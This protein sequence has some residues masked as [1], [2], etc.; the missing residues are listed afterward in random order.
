MKTQNISN[1]R[2]L[3]NEVM[4]IKG[5]SPVGYTHQV[6]VDQDL[7]EWEWNPDFNGFQIIYDDGS[8]G[9]RSGGGRQKRPEDGRFH[10]SR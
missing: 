7:D 6:Y 4:D 3:L 2:D 9:K 5:V 10:Q 1:K 8:T